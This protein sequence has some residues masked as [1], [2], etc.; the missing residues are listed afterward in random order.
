MNFSSFS[1]IRKPNTTVTWTTLPTETVNSNAKSTFWKDNILYSST[2]A[3]RSST[4]NSTSYGVQNTSATWSFDLSWGHGLFENVKWNGMEEVIYSLNSKIITSD[5]SRLFNVSLLSDITTYI[6]SS[7]EPGKYE[8]KATI[9]KDI[10][11]TDVQ[12]GYVLG[13]ED[14]FIY[15]GMIA[16]SSSKISGQYPSGKSYYTG[17]DTRAQLS[18]I[19]TDTLYSHPRGTVQVNCSNPFYYTYTNFGTYPMPWVFSGPGFYYEIDSTLTSYTSTTG[20]ANNKTL[21]IKLYNTQNPFAISMLAVG[22]QDTVTNYTGTYAYNE[23]TELPV[24]SS[25][26][27]YFMSEGTLTSSVSTNYIKRG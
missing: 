10:T 20:F 7:I 8:F 25:S 26:I 17:Y 6:K 5:R 16:Y 27:I 1:T 2:S 24:I 12:T 21:S 23:Y 3:T 11:T 18:K 4:F 15:G 14:V 13:N 9:V 22:Q 19:F